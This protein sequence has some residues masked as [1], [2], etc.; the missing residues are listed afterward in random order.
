MGPVT[1]LLWTL[2]AAI[3]AVNVVVV[4]GVSASAAAE[5]LRRRREIRRLD[6]LWRL[7][8]RRSLRSDA[9]S[10]PRREARWGPGAIL[11]GWT[12]TAALV[13]ALAVLI[14]PEA[15]ELAG[16]STGAR[17]GD[18]AAV[19]GAPTEGGGDRAAEPGR[20]EHGDDPA[21]GERLGAGELTGP[22]VTLMA[23]SPTQVAVSWTTV[24]GATGYTVERSVDGRNWTE[25]A[26]TGADAIGY[27]DEDLAPG[28]TYYYRVAAAFQNRSST[29]S[30]VVEVTTALGPPAAPTLVVGAGAPG[31]VVLTW[32]AVEG[33]AD[34]RVERSADG[35]TGWETIGTTTAAVL[36][37]SDAAP[38]PGGTLWYRIVA[39]NA[40][41]D[42]PPSVPRS[43]STPAAPPP[44]SEA[45]PAGSPPADE[46]SA[47]GPSGPTGGTVA[48]DDGGAT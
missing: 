9:P 44:A 29:P 25:V 41:G 10:E 48:P 8:P 18:G 39:S 17:P 31:E 5:A 45:P 32:D 12:A 4:A 42:S 36:T 26:A 38:A 28:T 20:R 6:E 23:G 30:G 2:I 22:S 15:R 46:P 7:D 19:D 11:L 35:V 40:D 13:V 27:T 43:A 37:F 1:R 24:E 47:E 3:V 21:A 33:A 34:Y 14:S 16:L